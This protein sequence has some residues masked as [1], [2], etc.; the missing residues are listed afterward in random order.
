MHVRICEA[1]RARTKPQTEQSKTSINVYG[2]FQLK[3]NIIR[4]C[5][6]RDF[7]ICLIYSKCSLTFKTHKTV[8]R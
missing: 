5:N 1:I 6:N 7:Q 8:K 4:L 3:Y 2:H